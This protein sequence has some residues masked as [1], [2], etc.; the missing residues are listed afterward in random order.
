[1]MSKTKKLTARLRRR[2]AATATATDPLRCLTATLQFESLSPCRIDSNRTG[3]GRPMRNVLKVAVDCGPDM[4]SGWN[5][6][7]G[8]GGSDPALIGGPNKFT[9][10]SADLSKSDPDTVSDE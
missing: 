6:P 5:I 2:G 3:T 10:A 9:V 4:G 8:S 7:R 1:M